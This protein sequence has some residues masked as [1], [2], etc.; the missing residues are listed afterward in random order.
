MS[1]LQQ[2]PARRRAWAAGWRRAALISAALGATAVAGIAS[3]QTR[4]RQFT[5]Q[6]VTAIV[7]TL[8]D[9]D[10]KIYAIRLPVFLGDRI[11]GSRLYGSLPM[12]E[13]ERLADSL[14]VPLRTDANVIAV[15]DP[16]DAGDDSGGGGGGGDGGGPGSHINTQSAAWSLAD[17][18]R[19]L[20]T[21]IDVSAYQFLR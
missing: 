8:R 21:D 20:L 1:A 9:S 10:P 3:A 11:V 19:V 18:T 6:D 5:P 12:R 15:F 2:L 13:V 14:R 4:Q 16:R 17:R 7:N